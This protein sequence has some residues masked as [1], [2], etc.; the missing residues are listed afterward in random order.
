MNDANIKLPKKIITHSGNFHADE[1]FACAILDILYKGGVLIVRS[2]DPKVWKTADIMVDVGGIYNESL[3]H[4]DHHQEGGSGTRGN[5]VPYA[6][7]GLV[8]KK[9]GVQIAGSSYGAQIIDERLVQPIDAGDN[10]ISIYEKHGAVVPYL[11]HDA[12]A[13]F[14]PGWKES[15]TNDDGF[16]EALDIAKKII[17]REIILAS[18]EEEGERLSEEAYARM[19]DK[20]LV[21]LDGHYPW[22]TVLK[23][24]PEPLFVVK[25]D[26]DNKGKWKV[27]AIRDDTHSFKNRKNLPS[28]WAGKK[29]AE[30]TL[31]SGVPD[32]IFCHNKLFVAV[33][34]SKEGA[35]KLAKLAI[36]NDK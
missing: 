1:V 34:G 30:F 21:I 16:F 23:T 7:C 31:V 20:R 8:W 3:D 35:I 15:R 27:E 24:H 22:H 17:E 36:S 32:A 26:R 12:I 28:L 2:R 5:G 29:D 13:A 33:A 19:E 4:F 9:L 25:P 10:G 14:R 6:S 18:E 11:I